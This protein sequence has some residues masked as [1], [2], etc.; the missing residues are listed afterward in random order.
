ML[1][2]TMSNIVVWGEGKGDGTQ[3]C[4]MKKKKREQSNE[5]Y[6]GQKDKTLLQFHKR[7]S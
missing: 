1:C 2:L 6:L 5:I 3:E 4:K 7:S